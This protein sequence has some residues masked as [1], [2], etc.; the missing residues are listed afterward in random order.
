MKNLAAILLFTFLTGSLY[1][2]VPALIP[3]QAIA[4]DAS[5]QPLANTSVN[6]RFT[7]HDVNPTGPI[8]WQEIQTVNTNA[9]GLFTTQLG[10]NISLSSVDWG[11]DAKFMQVEMDLGNGFVDIGTQQ[12]L[13]VPYALQSQQANGVDFRIS[14]SGDSLIFGNGLFLII[15]GLSAQN[16]YDGLEG[17]D[18]TCGTQ[19]VHNPKL[20]Y[21]NLIDQEGNSYKTIVI[22]NQE[23]MAENLNVSIY[24]NGDS[25]ATGLTDFEWENTTNTQL[26]AWAYPNNDVANVC[27]LGKHY[28]WYACTDPRGLC[29]IGW[30]VPGN[31]EWTVLTD[32]LGGAA[33]AGGAMKSRG[34]IELG[35]GLWYAPNEGATNSSGFS[36]LPGGSRNFQGFFAPPGYYGTWWSNSYAGNNTA[37]SRSVYDNQ[38]SISY[39]DFYALNGFSVRCLKD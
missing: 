26:G 9:M 1:A 34:Q 21:G 27:P 24:R 29:P 10:S 38:T 13:S 28:N 11:R 14:F 32:F 36:G 15:D 3:Y 17:I 19:G 39:N 8:V 6:A 37:W 33:V 5:G 25:I 7:I 4:R 12:M 16:P 22:G 23:W 2:Q 20:N 35:N 18:H 30:H 31:D